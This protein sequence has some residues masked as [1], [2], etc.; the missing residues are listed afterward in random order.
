MSHCRFGLMQGFSSPTVW[1]LAA[2]LF[3]EV[4][5]VTKSTAIGEHPAKRDND[6]NVFLVLEL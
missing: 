1:Q 4:T 3:L 2:Y 5:I 6:C